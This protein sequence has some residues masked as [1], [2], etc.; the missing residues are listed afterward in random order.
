MIPLLPEPHVGAGL[1]SEALVPALIADWVEA[2]ILRCL[3]LQTVVGTKP[4]C[5]GGRGQKIS[6]DGVLVLM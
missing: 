1:V 5:G 4:H 3:D 6:L 2:A